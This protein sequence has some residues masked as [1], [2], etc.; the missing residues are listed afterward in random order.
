[1]RDIGNEVGLE[2]GQIHFFGNVAVCKPNSAYHERREC[3]QN[4]VVISEK[5]S[6]DVRDRRALVV[7]R[8]DQ[9]WENICKTA[10]LLWA[11]SIPICRS[12]PWRGIL[13]C[14]DHHDRQIG[15][16]LQHGALAA[17]DVLYDGREKGFAQ[18]VFIKSDHPQGNTIR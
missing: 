2:S 4:D 7:H 3:S 5:S 14:M 15:I 12:Y 18:I 11:A 13:R 6:S 17:Q 1:M 8:E 9:I 10:L 16:C